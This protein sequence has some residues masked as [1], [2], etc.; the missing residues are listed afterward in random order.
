MVFVFRGEK[1]WTESLL[2]IDRLSLLFD[3]LSST[4][5]SIL[6]VRILQCQGYIPQECAVMQSFYWA[7]RS[8]LYQGYVCSITILMKEYND[9][10]LSL[11]MLP[12]ILLLFHLSGPEW[13]LLPWTKMCNRPACS[14]LGKYCV[15]WGFWAV[16]Y[17]CSCFDVEYPVLNPVKTTGT[18]W[19]YI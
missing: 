8:R 4:I 19:Y 9:L 13:A 16:N 12:Q 17:G 15:P 3:Y 7:S 6:P 5:K 1:T 2:P 14:I 10:H 11:E 18:I